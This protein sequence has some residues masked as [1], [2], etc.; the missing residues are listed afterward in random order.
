MSGT[1]TT[2]KLVLTNTQTNQDAFD[3][4]RVSNPN[5][6]CELKS[7]IGKLPFVIDE[8]LVGAGATSVAILDNSYIQMGVTGLAGAT[9]KVIRQSYEYVPYQP[10][11]SKLMIFSAVLEAQQG[12]ITGVIS[13]I[14]CFDS[15]LEK[16]IVP[17]TGNGCFF[18]L[19]NK[20][21]YTVIRN[22]DVDNKIAQTA[23]NYDKF[24]G[25]GPS[26]FTINDF[27]KARILAI[28]QEWLGV[29]RV[30]FGFFINGSFHLGHSYNHF[31]DDGITSPYTKTAKLPVR[32]EITSTSSNYAEMRMICSSVISEGGFEPSGVSFSIGQKTGVSVGSTIVPI[33]SIKLRETEPF[34]HK[35]LILKAMSVLNPTAN[36]GTQWDIYIFPTV[37]NIVG[38]TWLDVDTANSF[39]QYNNSA[40]GI[41]GLSTGIIVDSGYTD[42]TNIAVYNYSKYLSSPL[43]NSGIAGRSKVLTLACVRVSTGG[44]DPTINGSLSWIEID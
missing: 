40:T 37:D 10:G 31:G 39:T 28:D 4:L 23:W 12:G 19:D 43:V 5:T 30:R 38:G 17:G 32:H 33:I 14:G 1:L 24:D 29:G 26:G 7:T 2:G 35:T 27:S 41:T 9:G 36:R 25:T 34:N 11:K 42:L 13:R 15:Y 20:T 16:T 21:L 3:R 22:N 18:E 44:L 8:M 6:L